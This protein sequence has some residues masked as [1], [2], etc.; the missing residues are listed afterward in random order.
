MVHWCAFVFGAPFGSVVALSC[1]LG[2]QVA[3]A[4]HEPCSATR[5]FGEADHPGPSR[6]PDFCISTSNPSG[7]R[8]KEQHFLPWGPGIHCFSETQLSAVSLP[9][10]KRQFQSS[11]RAEGRTVRALSGAPAPLRV[12]SLWAGT[13]S[14]VLQVSDLPCRE[15]NL[16]WPSG[17]YETGRILLAQHFHE[18]TTLMVATVY[19]YPQGPTWPDAQART[20]LLLSTLTKE[21]VF[22]SRGFRVICGDFNHDLD[23]LQQCAVWESQG[24]VEAQDLALRLWNRPPEPT[25]KHSTRRDFVWL[26]P[27]AAAL[28]NSVSISE[29]YQEHSTLIAGFAL[30]GG[31]LAETSWPLPAEL[32]WSEVGVADWHSHGDQQPI[33]PCTSCTPDV[34]FAR[35]SK[36]VEHS[37]DGFLP[38]FP[39]GRPP[40]SS[41][42]RGQRTEPLRSNGSARPPKPSRPG[43]V[44]MRHDGLGAEVR[45]WFQQLRRLQSLH[46]SVRA[47]SQSPS[48]LEYRLSLWQAIKTARGFRSGFASWW[49]QRPVQLVGSPSDLPAGVPDANQA[50]SMYEDF[51]CNYRRL[52]DWHLRHRTKILDAKYDRSLSQLYNDLRDPA[53]DQV[54]TL[55]IQKTHTILAVSPSGD[56]V[57]LETPVDCRGSSTWNIDGNPVTVISCDGDLCNLATPASQTGGELEQVQTL[58][59]VADLHSEFKSLWAPRWQ[60]HGETSPANWRR[61]LD[62]A[63]A[64]LPR[65]DIVLPDITPELWYRAVSRYKPRAARGPDGW[66]K[67]DLLH[68]PLRRTQE[69]LHFLASIEQGNLEWPKQLVVGFV[70]LLCKGNGHADAQGYRPICL[71]SIVYRTWAGIRARQALAALRPLLP[72]GLFG[73]I[74]GHEATELWYTVQIDIEL[75]CQGG[76]ALSGLSTDVVK[77]FNHLPREPLLL[78]A[79]HVGLPN[80]LLR[81]WAAFLRATERRFMVRNQVG[82]AILSSSGFPEGDPLSPLAM[83]LADYAFHVYMQVF[84]AP[85]RALSF[86]DNWACTARTAPQLIHASGVLSYFAD[87]LSLPLDASKTFVW[88]ISP[89]DRATLSFLGHPVLEATRELGGF[90]SFGPRVRNSA[91]KDR[92][93]ALSPFWAALR[94]SRAP[95]GLKLRVLQSKFWAK[96]LHGV[97]GCPVSDSQLQ[98]LRTAATSA[99]RIRPGGASSLLR[100]GIVQ[101]LT[102]DPGFFQLWACVRDLRRMAAKLP[103]FGI[104]WR[105]FMS[106]FDGR[107]LHGPFTKLVGVLSQVGWCILEP[108]WLLDH[109]G[110]RHNFLR[111]P[112][113][114]LRRLLEHAW[115]QHVARSHNHRKAMADL[116]GL[117]SALLQADGKRLS[118]LDTAR[119]A[120]VR[121]GAFLFGHQHSH[122]DLTKSGLCAECQV[123]DTVEHRLRSCPNYIDLRQAHQAT[124]DRW[125][126]FPTSLT[127]HLLPSANPHLPALRALLHNAADTTGVFFCSGFGDGWQH[128]FT[129]GACT[130]HE[131]ADFALAGWGLVHAQHNRAVACGVLPGIHQSAPRAELCA[132]TAAARWALATGCSCM[133]WTDALNVANGVEA[134]QAGGSRQEDADADL[135]IILEG[136][137]SQLDSRRFLVRH[138]PSHLDERLTEAPMEDWLANSNNHAD[139]LAGIANRNRPQALVEI[140]TA[141]VAYHRDVLQVL[142]A[143]RNIFFGIADRQ[144]GRGHAALTES[145]D[146]WEPLIPALSTVSRRID[147]DDVVPLNWRTQ[148]EAASGE[149]PA[150]FTLAVCEFLFQQDAQA[151][152]AYEITWLELVFMLHLEG[153]LRY[154]VCNKE[155]RW[156][157]ASQVAFLPP[158]P[159][160]AGRLALVRRAVRPALHGLGLQRLMVRDLDLTGFGIGFK[161]DGLV[162]GV[163]SGLYLRARASLGQFV[164]GRCAGS[165]A[166]LARP[167]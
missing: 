57:H 162:I 167:L 134:I 151:A 44:G 146:M 131:H 139:L 71:Y 136:L 128:L 65:N 129:D 113:A 21:V 2:R 26:S 54:D 61:F 159:T 126:E 39:N 36:A 79:A 82:E 18:S 101:P 87:L 107:A 69:L 108:P 135:W 23:R 38:S 144:S 161:L 86:V 94:R 17:L 166:A 66:A 76:E 123:P 42:G 67:L 29:T 90:L 41:F 70:I 52:E 63:T 141:A 154:P 156:V 114:L 115:L 85:A 75:C 125:D 84:A 77:C 27:E 92:C 68:L 88:A 45:R 73:F 105:K 74:P 99:L 19:G 60:L 40:S 51:R 119:Y 72:D 28:C 122:Y 78:M 158:A 132:M 150:D 46:H 16:I 104:L 97:S 59:S 81:P 47:A 35:F 58:S 133:V 62:F 80:R 22:G 102:A 3:A 153:S 12:N 56:Q 14:G 147:L 127:H 106:A 93:N 118:A 121:S 37:L 34:W 64:F 20:D 48:A 110:L 138:V 55:Q 96:A 130:E 117:D 111:A 103:N 8:A 109:E 137:L 31:S 25:C 157:S 83:V 91:L 98:Q 11:A 148:V 89:S 155:G 120:A 100:L 24:W 164:Q 112:L 33:P 160:V 145:E 152:E 143:L 142:R 13:W 165:R 149:L 95:A 10:S 140:F 15:H 163:S 53:P 30:S 7:L 124:I 1:A 6:V 50:R 116:V 49:R 5:R 9:A 4:T 43:E 32:P